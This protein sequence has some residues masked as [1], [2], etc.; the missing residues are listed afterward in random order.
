MCILPTLLAAPIRLHSRSPFDSI[1]EEV[2][3]VSPNRQYRGIF[4][5]TTPA[6]TGPA[7]AGHAHSFRRNSG[8]VFTASDSS[9]SHYGT[10]EGYNVTKGPF[11][12]GQ[13]S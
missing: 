13:C 2:L 6:T 4:R 1:R 9:S 3:T 11:S 12:E 10:C 7:T 8:T 5:P